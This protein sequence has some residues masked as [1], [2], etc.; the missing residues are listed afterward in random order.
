MLEIYGWTAIKNSVK[1]NL[2]N[3]IQKQPVIQK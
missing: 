2:A 1:S 3:Q